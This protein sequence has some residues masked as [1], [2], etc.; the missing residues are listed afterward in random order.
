MARAKALPALV[1][2]RRAILAL[3][4]LTAFLAQ[5][6]IADTHWHWNDLGFGVSFEMPP[7]SAKVP[8]I[9][10]DV[11]PALPGDLC[12]ICQGIAA[13]ARVLAV[14]A[15]PFVPPAPTVLASRA[16]DLERLIKPAVSHIWRGR[17]PPTL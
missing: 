5:V 15:L 2:T 1:L 9:R 17:G 7:A 6:F 3:A 12:P 11:A 16:I 10:G 4:A 14:A 13:S 8:S